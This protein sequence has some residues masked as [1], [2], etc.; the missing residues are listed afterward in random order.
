MRSSTTLRPI[1]PGVDLLE[2]LAEV[3]RAGE[4][5]ID[6]TG[7]LEGIEL[8][9]AGEATDPVRALKGRFTLLHLAGPSGGP[10]AATLA[11][12]SDGGIEVRGGV[13]VR[14]R[15]AGVTL[16]V[17]ACTAAAPT[18]ARPAP[19]EVRGRDRVE[20]VEAAVRAPAGPP[21]P[22]WAR[23]AA[24]NAAAAER[25]AEEDEE[26]ELALPEAGDL[27]DHFAFGLCEVLTS[28][29]DRLRIRDVQGPGRIREVS[30]SM[31]RVVGPTESDGKRLFRLV[32]KGSGV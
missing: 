26:L 13:L 24:A 18:V 29:G 28:D 4:A 14:A 8:R 19:S 20:P 3:S 7:H 31:L 27:V 11:R 15:S 1:G 17:H 5:W 2:A 10:Y 30:L 21:A 22:V 16:A 32:R 6:G 12:A 9:V 25:D 23:V